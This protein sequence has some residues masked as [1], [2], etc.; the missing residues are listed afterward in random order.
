VN[1]LVFSCFVLGEQVLQQGG[2]ACWQSAAGLALTAELF[3]S[4]IAVDSRDP[5]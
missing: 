1:H 2:Q 3:H 4:C 5:T